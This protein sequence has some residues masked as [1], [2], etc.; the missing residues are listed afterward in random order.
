M[1]LSHVTLQVL[2]WPNGVPVTS[3]CSEPVALTS[4]GLP[5]I[6]PEGLPCCLGPDG[7]TLLTWHGRALLGPE[8]GCVLR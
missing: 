7:D 5:I 6:G 1:L 2:L 8:V 3:G 4:D